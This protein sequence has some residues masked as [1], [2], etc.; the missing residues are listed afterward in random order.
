VAS[1]RATVEAKARIFVGSEV[2]VQ[3]A[4]DAT[5]APDFPYPVSRVTR[6]RQAGSLD[7]DEASYDLLVIEPDDFASAA[8]W[9]DAFS[10]D[11]L[12][13][14]L[15]RLSAPVDDGVPVVVANGGGATPVT[16]SIGQV[17]VPVTVVGTAVTF[18]GTS[19]DSR[20]L[21]VMDAAALA[22]AFRGLPD[23]LATPRA[24]TEIWVDGPAAE[25]QQGI[26]E[27]GVLP[28]LVLSA[29][30]VEDIPFIAAAVQTFLVLQVLALS[31]VALVVV[32]A[33]VYLHAKQRSRVV[34]TTLSDRMGMPRYTMRAASIAE[35]GAMLLVSFLVGTIVGVLSASIVVPSIDP[36]P[37]I[38]PAPLIV[39]PVAA[40]VVTGVCLVVASVVGGAIA[41]RGARHR[42]T[43]EVMRVAE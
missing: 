13:V 21:V 1:L 29:E 9:N 38:P 2:Q 6:F 8:Y 16:A 28:Q 5:P 35:L 22:A 3:V 32:V 24:I 34:A 11:P 4:S 39:V 10:A 23:P 14:L 42:S 36:L 15:E 17:D 25:V 7:D 19:S 41:D 37:T 18:P 33:V 20:P 40:V 26:D 12:P 30:E 31:A 43:A 27:L